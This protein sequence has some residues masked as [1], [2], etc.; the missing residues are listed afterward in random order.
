VGGIRA[1][2][3][4]AS[5][6]RAL[7]AVVATGGFR[8]DPLGRLRRTSA[9]VG[10]T[11]YGEKAEARAAIRHVKRVHKGI[12][13]TDPIT[14]LTYDANA[15]DL[16]A[17]VHNALVES[18]VIAGERYLTGFDLGD[19][20]RYVSEMTVIGR[21]M[22]APS[23]ELPKDVVGVRRWMARFPTRMV[24]ETTK[25]ALAQLFA[26]RVEPVMQPIFDLCV[27]A[28]A[29]T[30]PAWMEEALP[31]PPSMT[32]RTLLPWVTRAGELLGQVLLPSPPSIQLA[33]QRMH[34]NWRASANRLEG[35]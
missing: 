14:G 11:T 12:V 27:R 16:T 18:M 13:G 22:G 20:D 29:C 19:L 26:M 28:A 8:E 2:M 23:S 17:F 34:E 24:T 21:L 32:D 30:L 31:T 5:E 25:S 7:A 6:P 9:F 3:V 4:Q 35:N 33:K 15:P 1:L 10:V